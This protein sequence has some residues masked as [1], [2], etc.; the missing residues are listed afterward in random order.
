MLEPSL[1]KNR[2]AI[3]LFSLFFLVCI[4]MGVWIDH[5][6]TLTQ[7][8]LYWGIHLIGGSAI[9]LVSCFLFPRLNNGWLKLFYG[10]GL[11]I[12]WRIS[13]FPFM[14]FSGHGASIVEW[15]S[16]HLSESLYFP[17]MIY[18]PYFLLIALLNGFLAWVVWY[19]LKFGRWWAYGAAL[20]MILM[21]T[22]ISFTTWSDVSH[23]LPDKLWDHQPTYPPVSLPTHNPYLSRLSE[24]GYTFPQR[25]LFFAAGNTYAT[26]PESP[27][28][29][30][31]KGVLES[32]TDANPYASSEDRVY[33]HHLGYLVAHPFVGCRYKDTR[34]RCQQRSSQMTTGEHSP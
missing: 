5:C 26:I 23:L 22:L 10:V 34:S 29:R 1:Q 8:H 2:W 21:A 30:V 14:V 18:P 9:L 3:G 12:A 4:A 24:P 25:V 13:Y 16:V 33:E 32:Q 6:Q 17:V 11:F 27:W 28:A 15:V 19:L 31:V 20:P 7:A